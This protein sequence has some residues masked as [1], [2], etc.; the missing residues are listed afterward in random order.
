[1]ASILL[2]DDSADVR[3]LVRLLLEQG[4]HR[5]R[6]AD[7]GEAGLLEVGRERPDLILTDLAM[8]GLSGWEVVRA[9]QGHPA[10]DGIPIFAPPAIAVRGD[11]ERRTAFGCDGFPPNPI[12]DKN[13]EPTVRGFL[14]PGPRPPAITRPAGTAPSPSIARS[15]PTS[16]PTTRGRRVLVVDD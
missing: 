13:F 10:P 9:L 8:P 2:I 1:P 11:R 5:V 6:E 14:G 7:G 4:G 15:A 3:A 12:D 16:A